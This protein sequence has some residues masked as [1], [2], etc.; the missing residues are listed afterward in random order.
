MGVT[1]N[2]PLLDKQLSIVLAADRNVIYGL[3]VAITSSYLNLNRQYTLNCYVLSISLT[4]IEKASIRDWLSPF[5]SRLKLSFIDVEHHL[6]EGLYT[7]GRFSSAIYARYFIAELIPEVSYP[8]YIDTD[9]I[10][11]RDL[12]DLLKVFN[13]LMAVA[14]VAEGTIGEFM[15]DDIINSYCLERSSSYFNSG[16]MLINAPLWR[17]EK[18]ANKLLAISKEIEGNTGFPDQ[19]VLNILFNQLCQTVD[20]KW[21]TLVMVKPYELPAM[22]VPKQTNVHT[23]GTYK[24]W[25]FKRRG[26]K[27][28][29][30]KFYHYLKQTSYPNYDCPESR[31]KHHNILIVNRK[32]TVKKIFNVPKFL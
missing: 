13:P 8:I 29:I 4:D 19:D 2:K 15:R 27:T 7:F 21:N 28:I 1:T 6:I 18:Y 32:L 24:P 9:I 17:K 14:A 20:E 25:M 12:S 26:S 11:Q 31:F 5:Y 23:V 16:F 30:K 3:I 22:K 10:I